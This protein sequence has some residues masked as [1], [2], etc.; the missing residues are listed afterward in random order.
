MKLTDETNLKPSNIPTKE[1][2]VLRT[3]LLPQDIIERGTWIKSL[4]IVKTEILAFE[5]I[6]N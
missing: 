4:A 6:T 2:V 1:T 3:K 5:K